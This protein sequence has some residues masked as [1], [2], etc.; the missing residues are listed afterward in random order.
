MT[1]GQIFRR[2]CYSEKES[3][4][5]R[6]ERQGI[7]T[8]APPSGT[9]G[10]SEEE[11]GGTNPATRCCKRT[12]EKKPRR[13]REKE[14]RSALSHYPVWEG[15]RILLFFGKETVEIQ[16]TLKPRLGGREPSSG[17]DHSKTKP[18]IPV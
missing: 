10:Y 7:P 14:G 3:R 9:G 12:W 16:V 6:E 15:D 1:S 8:K 4:I 5:Y 18:F 2:F 13:N 17:E 11:R